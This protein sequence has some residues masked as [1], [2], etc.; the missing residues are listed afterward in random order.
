[1]REQTMRIGTVGA[2]LM[3]VGAAATPAC[4]ADAG[5]GERLARRWCAPCHVVAANQ[6][7]ATSEAPP[8]AVIAQSPDF[9]ARKL[10]FFLLN[11]HP[12]MPRHGTVSPGGRRPCRVY[13]IAQVTQKPGR[14]LR[15]EPGWV[16]HNCLSGWRAIA[17]DTAARESYGSLRR[18]VLEKR[19]Q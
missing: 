17:S 12:K 9:D 2:L 19:A 13:C 16:F 3:V 11:P 5:N 10:A 4:S 18:K 6:R 14:T 1:M 8:F 7:Q 15:R